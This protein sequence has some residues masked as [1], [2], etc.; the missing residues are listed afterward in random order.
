MA[1]TAAGPPPP[2]PGG[3]AASP[4]CTGRGQRFVGAPL[5]GG[6]PARSEARQDAGG[7]PAVAVAV[8]G[9][10]GYPA[11]RAALDS[12]TAFSCSS[13]SVASWRASR[14]TPSFEA[15]RPSGPN[16]RS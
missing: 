8:A 9:V 11:V 12:M 15:T 7:T 2:G 13:T 5:D 3:G 1:D 14:S 4:D 10:A 16:G 6:K